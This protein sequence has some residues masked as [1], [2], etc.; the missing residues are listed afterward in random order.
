MHLATMLRPAS[1]VRLRVQHIVVL[2]F[3][4]F[5]V[6]GCADGTPTATHE[7]PSL[8]SGPVSLTMY[9]TDDGES[10]P[11]VARGS[12]RFQLNPDGSLTHSGTT[13]T[14]GPTRVQLNTSP[15]GTLASS[16]TA[17]TPVRFGRGSAP[18]NFG[19]HGA[20][21]VEFPSVRV[22]SSMVNGERVEL[23]LIPN[24]GRARGIAGMVVR[25]DGKMR[26]M[27]EFNEGA[28]GRRLGKVRMVSYD[29]KGK[30][31]ADV[32]A[33]MTGVTSPLTALGDSTPKSG[34]LAACGELAQRLASGVADM[35]LPATL[36]AQSA[37]PCQAEFDRM[38]LAGITLAG[39]AA[40]AVYQAGLCAATFITCPT[41]VA[42]TLAAAAAG[43]AYYYIAYRYEECRQMNPPCGEFEMDQCSGGS[44]GAGGGGGDGG[45]WESDGGS[46]GFTPSGW[47]ETGGGAGT[48]CYWHTTSWIQN[49]THYTHSEFACI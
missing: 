30:Q 45:S 43:A 17:R 13:L 36:H 23:F 49:G 27:L 19:A 10:S 12:T 8:L 40:N 32:D 44:D 20:T 25:V 9:P 6:A 22:S 26:Q 2:T 41:A 34:L 4:A 5:G 11:A 15:D 1:P 35:L 31:L 14:D 24:A 21:K 42:A 48:Y 38:T 33:D 37:D 46:G 3:A 39:V 18:G 28:G 7:P 29:D 47:T 16:V